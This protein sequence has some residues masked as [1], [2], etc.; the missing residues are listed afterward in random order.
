MVRVGS[1]ATLFDDR[2]GGGRL[3][4]A[5]DPLPRTR[6]AT[7][8]TSLALVAVIPAVNTTAAESPHLHVE[9][10]LRAVLQQALGG[11]TGV[12]VV[13]S[14]ATTRGRAQA[15]LHRMP[16]APH[17][18]LPAVVMAP[19]EAPSTPEPEP[20]PTTPRVLPAGNEPRPSDTSQPAVMTASLLA[21]AA[22]LRPVPCAHL[23]RQCLRFHAARRPGAGSQRTVTRPPHTAATTRPAAHHPV[24]ASHLVLRRRAMA[25]ARHHHAVHRLRVV[26]ALTRPCG[27]HGV[28][29]TRC[30]RTRL[31]TWK[32]TRRSSVRS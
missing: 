5:T 25:L 31:Q 6:A 14:S 13:M 7:Q 1:M 29:A 24:A 8:M 10:P 2:R 18:L 17:L 32:S 11:G 19:T 22:T 26:A 20:E 28:V 21:R 23:S 16:T 12:V 4:A 30:G 3:Y 9:L 27:G 15:L